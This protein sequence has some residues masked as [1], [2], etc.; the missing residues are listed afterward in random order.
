MGIIFVNAA[1][2]TIN[3]LLGKIVGKWFWQPK[4]SLYIEEIGL[5]GYREERK[6]NFVDR[7][8]DWVHLQSV[9]FVT[10]Q[11]MVR[12]C[13]FAFI[14]ISSINL[15]PAEKKIPIP[16]T[17]HATAT[18]KKYKQHTHTH[19]ISN[20]RWNWCVYWKCSFSTCLDVLGL[21]KL[22]AVESV[23]LPKGCNAL[24]VGERALHRFGYCMQSKI[25][26]PNNKK[27]H[28]NMSI[29]QMTVY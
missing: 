27:N 15:I 10:F 7:P 8:N 21:C 3:S 29:V 6:T 9:Y 23:P 13:C 28:F 5:S 4:W 24:P 17:K 20:R 18:S 22:F 11:T 19:A 2:W 14:F 16:F 1:K 26:L 12:L 25:L